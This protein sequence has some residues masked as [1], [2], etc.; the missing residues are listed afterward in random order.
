MS[1][2]SQTPHPVLTNN[3]S[4]PI[5]TNTMN[6]NSPTPNNRFGNNGPKLGRGDTLARSPIVDTVGNKT[7]VYKLI[8]FCEE[9]KNWRG[10]ESLQSFWRPSVNKFFDPSATLLLDFLGTDEGDTKTVELPAE[11]IP[12]YFKAKFD[13]GAEK[14]RLLMATPYELLLQS[15]AAVV[16]CPRTTIL[17]TYPDCRVINEGHLRVTFSKRQK[18]ICWEFSSQSHEEL[19]SRET[20]DRGVPSRTCNRYGLPQS[21]MTLMEVAVSM[22]DLDAEITELARSYHAS[23]QPLSRLTLNARDD[24]QG[25]EGAL[26]GMSATVSD[27][28]MGMGSQ[29]EGFLQP[30]WTNGGTDSFH[31]ASYP[32]PLRQTPRISHMHPNGG[33]R[34][35]VSQMLPQSSV[36]VGGEVINHVDVAL[37]RGNRVQED[38]PELFLPPLPP[39]SHGPVTEHSPVNA[40]NEAMNEASS[41]SGGNSRATGKRR[42]TGGNGGNRKRRSTGINSV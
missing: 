14:E 30:S 15:G 22:G 19:Y 18:I 34:Q 11:F 29:T 21:V 5:V 28:L 27:L 32:P 35:I 42:S 31:N 26:F 8:K 37:R 17:T 25:V 9:Q 40:H 36:N 3:F 23:G 6:G 10:G 39:I 13:A 16:D 2:L 7:C 38:P 12:R 33:Q 20:I 24:S 4:G 1:P 41:P